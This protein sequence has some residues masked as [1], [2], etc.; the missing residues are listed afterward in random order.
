LKVLRGKYRLITSRWKEII[1]YEAFWI[2]LKIIEVHGE[3]I[4]IGWEKI[5]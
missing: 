4:L 3:V 2:L 1:D 5:I